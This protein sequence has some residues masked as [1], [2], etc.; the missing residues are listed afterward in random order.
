MILSVKMFIIDDIMDD[1]IYFKIFIIE[2][3][4]LRSE[5]IFMEFP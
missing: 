4:V 5:C 2:D 1:V 3:I